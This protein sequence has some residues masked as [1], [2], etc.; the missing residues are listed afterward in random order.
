MAVLGSSLA[1]TDVN[2]PY[3]RSRVCT[4]ARDACI[5]DPVCHAAALSANKVCPDNALTLQASQRS[6]VCN[7][8]IDAV[9]ATPTGAHL[10]NICPNPR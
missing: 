5:A 9:I 3:Y 7:Q 4:Q 10:V 6:T 8:A 1:E 2:R